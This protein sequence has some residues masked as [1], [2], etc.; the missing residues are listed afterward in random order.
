MDISVI[1]PCY[2]Q[3]EYLPDCIESVL[4][5]TVQPKEIIVIDDGSTDNT[6]DVA[7]KYPV[8]LIR[9]VNKGLPSARNTGIM[10][11]TGDYILPLDADDMLLDTCIEKMTEA[12]KVHGSD[13]IAPSFK[14]FGVNN[15]EVILAGIPGLKD[16]ATAN[17]LPYFCAIKKSVLLEVGGYSPRMYWGWE[18]FHLWMDIFKRGATLCCLQDILVLYRTKEHS[19]IHVADA[20]SAELLAQMRKDHPIVYA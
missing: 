20:H 17:R 16:F 4:G 1:I 6:Q 8:K 9:Q 11:S 7:H 3:A 10:N 18:D 5:Q 13:V 19:M 14:T 2:N 12:I 15:G